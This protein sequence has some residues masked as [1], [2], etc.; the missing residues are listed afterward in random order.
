[1]QQFAV[2]SRDVRWALGCVNPRPAA[3]GSQEAGFTQPRDH[4]LAGPCSFHFQELYPPLIVRSRFRPHPRSPPPKCTD[5]QYSLVLSAAVPRRKKGGHVG[6]QLREGLPRQ[7]P[8]CQSGKLQAMF[9][10]FFG[11]VISSILRVITR[12][13]LR[14]R[15]WRTFISRRRL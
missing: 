11:N 9:T 4:T 8:R 12:A 3:R 14:L 10:H 2:Q 7:T 15:L 6:N 13:V 1:M 5:M